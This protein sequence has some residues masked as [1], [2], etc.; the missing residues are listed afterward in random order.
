MLWSK[1]EAEAAVAAARELAPLKPGDERRVT[2]LGTPQSEGRQRAV[3]LLEA[4]GYEAN[5]VSDRELNPQTERIEHTRVASDVDLV[6]PGSIAGS[7]LV[8][9]LGAEGLLGAIC[10]LYP[11]RI[12]PQ[13]G[14][15]AQL[16]GI[17]LRGAN[18]VQLA[19]LSP[20]AQ[21]LATGLRALAYVPGWSRKQMVTAEVALQQWFVNAIMDDGAG[22]AL[23]AAVVRFRTTWA[24]RSIQWFNDQFVCE[25][26]RCATARL[27]A[28]AARAIQSWLNKPLWTEGY[29]PRGIRKNLLFNLQHPPFR[30]RRLRLGWEVLLQ[31]FGDLVPE[32]TR[33]EIEGLVVA[34][35][36]EAADTEAYLRRTLEELGGASLPQLPM[37]PMLD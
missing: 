12:Y 13:M 16:L 34:A 9:T 35:E 15:D 6:P 17:G 26:K 7:A 29:R 21:Q 27:G 1:E 4:A 20:I 36:Q 22:P 28:D 25:R 33:A 10:G 11:D 30:G 31:V 37:L 19:E 23:A 5:V 24:Q 2:L 8:I 3:Q 18:E 32:P 14:K